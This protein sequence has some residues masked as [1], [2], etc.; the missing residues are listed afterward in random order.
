MIRAFIALPL[1]ADLRR[2][3]HGFSGG[4]PGAAWHPADAYHI[5]LRFLGDI[6]EPAFAELAE[7]LQQVHAYRFDLGIGGFGTF[8]TGDALRIL[9]AGVDAEPALLDLKRRVDSAVQRH[10]FPAEERRFTPHITLARLHQSPIPRVMDW[11]AQREPFRWGDITV[12]G[13]SLYSSWSGSEG[14]IYREEAQFDL[15]GVFD[16]WDAPDEDG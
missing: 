5:T 6:P 1:P 13:F 9:W 12:G 14:P 11:I 2:R 15:D 8:G 3:L 16:E 4:I 7:A 10:G